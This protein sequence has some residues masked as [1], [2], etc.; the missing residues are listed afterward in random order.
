MYRNVRAAIISH[1][2]QLSGAWWINHICSDCG[3]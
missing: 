3:R 1:T 2:W